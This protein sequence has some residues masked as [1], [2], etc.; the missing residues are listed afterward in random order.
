MHKKWKFNQ[1]LNSKSRSYPNINEDVL[2]KD[3]A[4]TPCENIGVFH[5]KQRHFSEILEFWELD[6][7]RY[8]TDL[9]NSKTSLIQKEPLNHN[10]ESK[11]CSKKNETA[12]FSLDNEKPTSEMD[13]LDSNRSDST[14]DCESSNSKIINV[15]FKKEVASFEKE[16]SV[17]KN[18]PLKSALNVPTLTMENEPGHFVQ[19]EPKTESLLSIRNEQV[20][21]CVPRSPLTPRV[22]PAMQTRTGVSIIKWCTSPEFLKP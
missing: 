18:L 14:F 5:G 9:L 16:I 13:H 7:K 19:D 3:N 20:F 4:Q 17:V 10:S 12:R 1:I 22:L 15:Y 11:T 2:A 21:E 8:Q 6:Y